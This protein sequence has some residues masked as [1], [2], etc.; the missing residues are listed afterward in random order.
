MIKLLTMMEMRK[1]VF[2]NHV[3]VSRLMNKCDA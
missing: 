2:I 1:Q 3:V